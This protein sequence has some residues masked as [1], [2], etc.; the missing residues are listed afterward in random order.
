MEKKDFDIEKLKYLSRISNIENDLENDLK[1]IIKFFECINKYSSN[2]NSDYLIKN[3]NI[4]EFNSLEE[5]IEI[6]NNLRK[7]I[8]RNFFEKEDDFCIVPIVVE[9]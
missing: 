2:V 8:I 1:K 3:R 7:D 5:D 6:K 4:I 9:R